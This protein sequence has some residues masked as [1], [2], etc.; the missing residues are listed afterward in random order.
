MRKDAL[1]TLEPTLTDWFGCWPPAYNVIIPRGT[2][3]PLLSS[4]HT[5]ICSPLMVKL[6]V[7]EAPFFSDI[8]VNPASCKRGTGTDTLVH[9]MYTC[10]KIKTASTCVIS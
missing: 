10:I 1:R 5:A 9:D 3:N 7:C 4:I 8:L 6:S 2:S